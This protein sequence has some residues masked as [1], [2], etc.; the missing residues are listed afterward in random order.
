MAAVR[1]ERPFAIEARVILPDRMHAIRTLPEGD[2][3]CSTRWR[4]LKA[5]FSRSID[6]AATPAPTRSRMD[7]RERMVWQRRFWDHRIR[8][9]TDHARHFDDVH[10]NP[11]KHGLVERVQDWPYSTFHHHVRIGT[12]PAAWTA[13][14]IPATTDAKTGRG[15]PP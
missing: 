1:R 6:P 15:E 4:H 14:P 13:G 7:K 8:D 9:D 10:F 12:Y 11:V 5:A 2:H 3:E